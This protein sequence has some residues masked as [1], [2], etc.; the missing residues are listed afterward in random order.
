M[1]ERRFG[2]V[3]DAGTAI[4]EKDG[5]PAVVASALGTTAYVG[6]LERGVPFTLIQA[7][8]K[9]DANRK[10]GGLIPDSLVPDCIED[11]WEHS[12]GAGVNL[13]CRVTD[14]TE[15]KATLTVYDRSV[16]RNAVVKFEA[17]NGGAWG[18]KRQTFVVDLAAVPTDI[19]SETTVLLPQT[20]HPILKDQFKGGTLVCSQTGKRYTIVSNAKSTG[21]AK[22]LLT[23]KGDS[24]LLTDY[25]AGTDKEFTI[26]VTQ[27]N[28]WGQEKHLAVVIKDGQLDPATEWGCDVYLNGSR[29]RSYADLS[30][31]PGSARYFVSIINEDSSNDYVRVTDLWAGNSVVADNR[32]ANYF[33]RV[34]HTEVTATAVGLGTALVLVNSSAAG[35]NTLAAFTFGTK[36]IP[37]VYELEYTGA[38]WELTSLTRQVTHTFAVPVS[39]TPYVADNAYSIGFTVTSVTPVSGEKFV[40]TVLP[41]VEGEAVNGRI[42]FPGVSGAPASGW[43]I[44]ANTE[45][46]ATIQVGDLT[47][48][49]TLAGTVPVRLEY[50][51]QL[52]DGYDGIAGLTTADFLKAY[53]IA[54]SPFNDT[55]DKGLG[56]IK[57]STPGI[58]VLNGGAI[59][60]VT[61]EK[62]GLAYAYAKNH[63]YRYEVALSVTDEFAAKAYV[64]D[65]LGKSAYAKVCMH[66]FAYVADPVLKGRLK[67]IPTT[68]MIQGR[69]AK[70]AKDYKGY[71]KVAAGTDVDLPRVVKLETGDT[72]LNGE[73]L[74][75]A[76]L[77][78]IVK[79]GGKWVLWGARTPTDNTSFLFCQHRELLSYYEHVLQESFDWIVFAINDPIEQP[80]AEAALKGFFLQEYRNRALRGDSFDDACR[81]KIDE[82]NNTNATRAAGDMNAEVRLQLADTVERF[83]IT[84]SKAGIFE[85]VS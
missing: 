24:K 6:I 40:I 9:K 73:V 21:L 85:S 16:V 74:N 78:R 26:E 1:A 68:G 66:G 28:A 22:T 38:A 67:V 23:L 20:F 50:P 63:Q 12:E 60:A 19:T 29:V 11:F 61:V 36:V 80:R 52:G 65:T 54:D 55:Q 82:E 49:G 33:G 64:Q 39:G 10:V 15:K 81:I 57:F 45:A 17:H 48:G 41:L 42:Y 31:D 37:D 53:S 46:G 70:V 75:P 83:N 30:M 69:E 18:G 5:E 13:F 51:Q 34:A 56:L 79:K 35:D 32:P 71:H 58:T 72:V 77:Q 76:G 44:N 8:G 62:A 27:T 84:V 43:L 14:G 25:G 3:Q 59:N 2:P 7:G 4:I 47:L